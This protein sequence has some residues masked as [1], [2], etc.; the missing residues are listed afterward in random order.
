MDKKASYVTTPLEKL[1]V[2][3]ESISPQMDEIGFGFAEGLQGNQGQF[4]YP[5]TVWGAIPALSLI[6][7]RK[8]EV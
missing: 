2:L 3:L 8:K 7:Y 6:V 4:V 5:T 1:C